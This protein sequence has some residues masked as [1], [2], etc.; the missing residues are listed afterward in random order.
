MASA[1]LIGGGEECD[2]VL[3]YPVVSAHHCLL[4]Q[5]DDGNFTLEDLNSRNG[6]FVNGQ[7]IAARVTVR[8]GDAITLGQQTPVAWPT[9]PPRRTEAAI[10][11]GRDPRCDVS[12]AGAS[13]S[14]RHA[15]LFVQ[16]DKCLLKDLGSSNGTSV[17]RPGQTIKVA[18]VSSGDTIYFGTVGLPASE[19]IQRAAG[20]AVVPLAAGQRQRKVPLAAVVAGGIAAV[21]VCA[22]ALIGLLVAGGGKRADQPEVAATARPDNKQQEE[23][24]GPPRFDG[25]SR[26]AVA[27]LAVDAAAALYCILVSDAEGKETYRVGTAW[28]ISPQT[29]VTTAAVVKATQTLQA[30]RFPKALAYSPASGA[31]IPITRMQAHP[32]YEEASALLKATHEKYEKAASQLESN[33]AAEADLAKAREQLLKL[34]QEGLQAVEQQVFYDVGIVVVPGPAQHVLSLSRDVTLRPKLK[35]RALGLAFDSEDPFFDAAAP[36]KAAALEGR[37]QRVLR[38]DNPATATQRIV[39][40]S[41][42]KQLELNYIGSA[43]LNEREEVIAM[44]S[45]PTPATDPDKPPPGTSFDAVHVET[46]REL[47]KVVKQ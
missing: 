23:P 42:S 8:A 18:R 17:G 2:I 4:C 22:I 36:M 46:I 14:D 31:K 24:T 5:R 26:P 16:R 21:V 15:V 39:I 27:S 19:L 3:D 45:R 33:P 10:T 12:L 30:D 34:R 47:L 37:L 44:Y 11:I 29:L 35:V 13:V 9:A 40:D 7:Q 20:R 25:A 32:R 43:V 28:A 38:H 41:D 6:T 1:W